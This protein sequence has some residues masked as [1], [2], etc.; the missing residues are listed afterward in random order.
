MF[1]KSLKIQN[2]QSE[3]V[4]SRTIDNP[5]TPKRAKL[6]A[7]IYKTLHRNLKIDKHEPH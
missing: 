5:M 4:N 7:T 2:G 1:K 6:Q 3:A